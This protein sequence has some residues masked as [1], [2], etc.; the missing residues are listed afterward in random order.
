MKQKLEELKKHT[1]SIIGLERCQQAAVG[2]PLI[3]KEDGFHI[4]FEVRSRHIGRQPGDICFPGG[5]MEKGESPKDTAI[6]ESAEE[7]LIEPSRI[8]ILGPM[9]IFHTERQVIYPFAMRLLDYRGSFS[10]AEVADTFTVPLDF[11][12]KT[13]PESYLMRIPVPLQKDFPYERIE[14]GKDYGWRD[15]Q[16]LVYFY[17]YKDR[18]IWGITAKILKSFVDVWKKL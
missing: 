18:C 15:R 10:E 4:L 16:E 3:E 9:D 13:E 2:I 1:P 12:L 6:R 5:R 8:E 17:Q 14:G 11:F 7:L